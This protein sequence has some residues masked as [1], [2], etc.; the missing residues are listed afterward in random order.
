[1]VRT[2]PTFMDDPSK[3]PKPY[4]DVLARRRKR[5][6]DAIT[7]ELT[8]VLTRSF[9]EYCSSGQAMPSSTVTLRRAEL[10][11]VLEKALDGEYNGEP[12]CAYCV[13]V[14]KTLERSHEGGVDQVTTA[15][16]TPP[17]AALCLLQHV[18][19]I[20][21]PPLPGARPVQ[22]SPSHTRTCALPSTVRLSHARRVQ[23]S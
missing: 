1:M 13:A 8:P 14:T 12:I 4:R 20:G 23:P 15:L 18:S 2:N 5:Q 10:G 6:Q 9:A 3:P 11:A 19:A 17:G 16:H 7:K 21:G 22:T